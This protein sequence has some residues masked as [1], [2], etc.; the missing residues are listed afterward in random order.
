MDLSNNF[1]KNRI[2]EA[3]KNYY[4]KKFL[5]TLKMFKRPKLLSIIILCIRYFY[6]LELLIS[7]QIIQTLKDI[8]NNFDI[9]LQLQLLKSYSF[10]K[11]ILYGFCGFNIIIFSLFI[12]F[13]I[14]HIAKIKYTKFQKKVTFIFSLITQLYNYL[15]FIPSL[16][17]SISL[18]GD[19][20]IE[21]INLPLTFMISIIIIIHDQ[22][23]NIIVSDYLARNSSFLTKILFLLLETIQVFI[24]AQ[25]KDQKGTCIISL[26]LGAF[27]IAL[28]FQYRSNIISHYNLF[29]SL[30]VF[31][32]TSI[33]TICI[34]S[35]I[36][37]SFIVC[38][39]IAISL[40]YSIS[41]IVCS[42]YYSI[43]NL[44]SVEN[45]VEKP[46][47]L[48]LLLRQFLQQIK[49]EFENYRV[50]DYSLVLEQIIA[51][52]IL[53]CTQYPSCY[54]SYQEEKENATESKLN[55]MSGE[56]RKRYLLDFIFKNLQESVEQMMKNKYEIN[57]ELVFSYLNFLIEIQKSKLLFYVE[58]IRIQKQL[59]LSP[60]QMC[61]ANE[62]YDKA[63][64]VFQDLYVSQSRTYKSDQDKTVNNVF[65]E[66]I[67][68]S[69]QIQLADLL[70]AISFDELINKAEKEFY[71][72]IE[73]KDDILILL[74]QD[75][76]S[77][78]I[79]K[80]K[81][82]YYYKQRDDIL[83][84]LKRLYKINS[85]SYRLNYLID[86]YCIVMSFGGTKYSIFVK[87]HVG[88]FNEFDEG[89]ND[90]SYEKLK[91]KI[92]NQVQLFSRSVSI[93]FI[94]LID[95]PGTIKRLQ[96]SFQQIFGYTAQEAL[97]KDI[98]LIIP[99]LIG[100]HHYSL[101]MEYFS[102]PNVYENS[103][104]RSSLSSLLARDA[105]G[106]AVPISVYFKS[107]SIGVVDCGLTAYI[108][109]IKNDYFYL[110]LSEN[111]FKVQLM[112]EELFEKIFKDIVHK[113]DL[114]KIYFIKIIPM[115][116]YFEKLKSNGYLKY[117]NCFDTIGFIPKQKA[118]ISNEMSI[119]E[120]LKYQNLLINL[121]DLNLQ[122]YNIYRVRFKIVSVRNKFFEYHT[123]EFHQFRLIKTPQSVKECL[124]FLKFQFQNL[125]NININFERQM[126]SL[127]QFQTQAYSQQNY[128]NSQLGHYDQDSDSL[129][130][131][132]RPQLG[133]VESIRYLEQPIKS[134][135]QSVDEFQQQ[136]KA[137]EYFQYNSQL[138][139]LK[140]SPR[141]SNTAAETDIHVKSHFSKMDVQ[142]QIK[143]EN[144]K[145]SQNAKTSCKKIEQNDFDQY[146]IHI[147]TDLN[148]HTNHY[149]IHSPQVTSTKQLNQNGGTKYFPSLKKEASNTNRNLNCTSIQTI[150]D[151]EQYYMKN[152]APISSQRANLKQE[153]EVEHVIEQK[154][155]KKVK[156]HNWFNIIN[157]K[158]KEKVIGQQNGQTYI[159]QQ[160]LQQS[161]NING[162][163]T[164]NLIQFNLFSKQSNRAEDREKEIENFINSLAQIESSK[165]EL[166]QL[167]NNDQQF[168]S[169]DDSN[170][171]E[172]PK[173]NCQK[174]KSEEDSSENSQRDSSN[175]KKNDQQINQKKEFT[176]KK[177]FTKAKIIQKQ[178]NKNMKRDIK[179]TA[180][181]NS[182]L[183][184]SSLSK[185]AKKTLRRNILEK[186]NNLLLKILKMFGI[187][188]LLCIIGIT[189]VTYF[190]MINN[191]DIAQQTF[192]YLPWPLIFRCNY[193]LSSHYMAILQII[194]R[195]VFNNP[196]FDT[197]YQNDI[198][199]RV[200]YS[201]SDMNSLFLEYE[202]GD[203]SKLTFFKQV[204]YQQVN[205]I[206]NK[207]LESVDDDILK[208]NQKDKNIVPMSMAYFLQSSVGYVYRY[209]TAQNNLYEQI[210][211]LDNVASL[212]SNVTGI[213]NSILQQCNDILSSLKQS[214]LI[215][216]I[217]VFFIIFIFVVSIHP[218]YAYAQIKQESILKLFATIQQNHLIE[219]IQPINQILLLAHTHQK[220]RLPEVL[221]RSLYIKKRKNI[222]ST[223][224][225][226]RIRKSFIILSI[227]VFC[228]LIIQPIINY[229]Y[230]S[231]F[232]DQATDNIYLVSIL[233]DLRAQ[234]V[235]NTSQNYQ[236]L[237]SLLDPTYLLYNTNYYQNRIPNLV[238]QNDQ[239]IKGMID[240]LNQ[241]QG[242]KKY[243][244][245]Q[246]NSFFNQIIY[247]DLCSAM[248]NYPQYVQTQDQVNYDQCIKI[249]NGMLLNGFALSYKD[250]LSEFQ[251]LS[252]IY[253]ITDPQKLKYNL[254]EWEDRVDLRDF[255]DYF[256]V[257]S[258]SMNTIKNFI[259]IMMQDQLSYN[260]NIET[261]LLVYQY[262]VLAFVFYFGWVSFQKT[263][264]RE[265]FQVRLLLTILN[266]EV[267]LENPYILSFI[268]K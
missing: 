133:Q 138:D 110:M 236:Y 111:D 174:Q 149:E 29:L 100:E 242:K 79:L 144:T 173:K 66:E 106:W 54:C 8:D 21:Y 15:F 59:N 140:L 248:T 82:N 237:L 153:S 42:Q 19:S 178:I 118:F 238:I 108:E 93:L 157:Q 6:Q 188:S 129:K 64:N 73:L 252:G 264:K 217:V 260:Q 266:I 4:E 253:N 94:T 227:V 78:N 167:E 184:S 162:N 210:V 115:L 89:F 2:Q 117:Q 58:L 126:N 263:V 181:A 225:L 207:D 229:T 83:Q 24:Y 131:K 257:L 48:N 240:I 168:N 121:Q 211:R 212:I 127:I 13:F 65:R 92:Q 136:Q 267:I 195:K 220:I 95:S 152:L 231:D 150:I 27:K 31:S 109:K 84:T 249:R 247:G 128:F 76:I 219:M 192:K 228:A 98:S 32:I 176:D 17:F 141:P 191:F 169:E 163:K 85:K 261:I 75:F 166:D 243:N 203:Q 208:F 114:D 112:S 221:Q 132:D 53:N 12:I 9:L 103:L 105:N 230:I 46:Q 235:S 120:H 34:F 213:E 180:E 130:E 10:S 56:F 205:M 96:S 5:I 57:I 161:S 251:E 139:S 142:S 214:A 254:I 101:L 239:K 154:Q 160:L 37:F 125:L 33:T 216:M 175:Q 209:S 215:L 226:R 23:F 218:L 124:K 194:K 81:A 179:V 61:F 244:Q 113:N 232:Y 155:D 90:K 69:K 26:I 223:D 68:K 197:D 72:V 156:N 177:S 40:S 172:D 148:I 189:L 206:I 199:N 183:N 193:S 201:V 245:E 49:V 77:L 135:N 63:Q 143:D 119:Y 97:N 30:T 25:V 182:S 170:E 246:F 190:Q 145:Q 88:N 44:K 74:S 20:I 70:G 165:R 86:N 102:Q 255:D 55:L 47:V 122:E 91:I 80:K 99:K 116:K 158:I 250:F 256:T 234:S 107:D 41:C 258:Q 22:D 241:N 38:F 137:K 200:D 171:E 60:L 259:L 224:S 67:N 268:S 265:I 18:F 187:V 50:N 233:Y 151:D 3:I 52:H 16:Y 62:I 159:D 196:R 35:K 198:K 11:N 45:I 36:H 7:E 204:S 43:E 147:E 104:Q 28:S 146:D 222:S 185:N 202:K 123:I 39:L 164:S 51:D 134:D 71:K 186:K 87:E 1:L 262:V 14:L